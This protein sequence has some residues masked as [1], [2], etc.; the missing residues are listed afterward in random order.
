M[1]AGLLNPRRCYGSKFAFLI[2]VAYP[3]GPVDIIP[4]GLPVIGHLDQVAF[5]LGGPALAY[6]LLTP[7]YRRRVAAAR[8]AIASAQGLSARARAWLLDGFAAAFALP[9]LRLATGAW[10]HKREVAS[11]RHAFRRFTP[12]PPL[13]RALATI[14]AGREQLTRAMLASWLLADE[15]YR[16]RLAR[17]LAG[18]DQR[19]GSPLRVWSGP[20]VTFLHIEKT[21]GMAMMAALTAQFHP[22][23]IDADVRRAHPP[24]LFCHLPPFLLPQVR[25]RALVWGH[26]DAPS[27]DR[28]GDGRFTFTMLREPRAR[29]RSLYGYWRAKAALDLGWNGMNQPV[30][31]AQRLDFDVFLQLQDPMV[32]N[33]I[34]NVYVRRLTGQYATEECDPLADDP[35]RWLQAALG[36]LARLDFVGLTE[37][38]DGALARLGALLDFEPPVHVCP[39][40]V[41]HSTIVLGATAEAA[42]DRLTALDR[43]VY[44]AAV[45]LYQSRNAEMT[46]EL[47]PRKS[48]GW[49]I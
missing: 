27:I 15:A 45:D 22:L 39:V 37:D 25:R 47:T 49:P 11:F 41:T 48:P 38:T 19:P 34:D 28:L 30:L 13:M 24:H 12:L 36:V 4:N 42:L 10:P 1:V 16:G 23:Q 43:V 29:I 5:V 17:E 18:D 33:Y 14:P 3:F 40:N 9:L 8:P 6:L 20:R 32:V 7:P 26:Y 2:G 35:E 44:A 21:A 46:A 31:L